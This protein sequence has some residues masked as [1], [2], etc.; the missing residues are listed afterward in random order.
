MSKKAVS[1]SLRRHKP[2]FIFLCF[3]LCRNAHYICL[4]IQQRQMV[5]FMFY[6]ILLTNSTFS[7]NYRLALHYPDQTRLT[8][9]LRTIVLRSFLLKFYLSSEFMLAGGH[10][11]NLIFTIY[12]TKMSEL[13]FDKCC[14]IINRKSIAIEGLLISFQHN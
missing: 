1:F 7:L 14:I 3:T 10:Q 11:R 12:L 2:V 9:R 13:Q 5:I 6:Y 4:Y 8:Y